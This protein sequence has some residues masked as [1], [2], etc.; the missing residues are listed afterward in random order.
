[1]QTSSR[2]GD[3]PNGDVIFSTF[4]IDVKTLAKKFIKQITTMYYSNDKF[5]LDL[6]IPKEL[7]K[8][9]IHWRTI[10]AHEPVSVGTLGHF[11]AKLDYDSNSVIGIIEGSSYRHD[12]YLGGTGNYNGVGLYMTRCS[13]SIYSKDTADKYEFAFV[14]DL[15]DDDLLGVFVDMRDPGGG[16]AFITRNGVVQGQLCK[17]LKEETFP[18]ICVRNY[19][20]NKPLNALVVP[21]CPLPF[22]WDDPKFREDDYLDSVLKELDQMLSQ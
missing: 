2:V 7:C 19:V 6:S 14:P 5:S 22:G 4:S 1:M 10:K 20:Y 11:Q 8:G 3:I 21:G 13:A 16:R 9:A 12:N 18:A 17:G 15:Q